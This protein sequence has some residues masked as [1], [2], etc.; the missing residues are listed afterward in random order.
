MAGKNYN[1]EEV[2]ELWKQ[3]PDDNIVFKA[4]RED[5]KE[6]PPEIQ[7]IIKDKMLHAITMEIPLIVDMNTGNNWLEAH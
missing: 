5:I 7:S 4:A 6:Y 1:I 2:K 3:E